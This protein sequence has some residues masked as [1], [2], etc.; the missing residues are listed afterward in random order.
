MVSAD[1]V[2][3]RRPPLPCE[4]RRLCLLGAPEHLPELSR[5]RDPDS[6]PLKNTAALYKFRRF[7]A[8]KAGNV[9]KTVLLIEDDR[10]VQSVY[11]RFLQ[12]HGFKV[13]IA[14]NGEEG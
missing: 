1:H 12:S 7:C 8:D 10:V 14:V 5:L 2:I 6:R 3:C 13:E 9:M 11:Q 4:E